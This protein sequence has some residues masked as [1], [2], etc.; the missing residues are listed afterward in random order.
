MFASKGALAKVWLAAFQAN[1]KKVDAKMAEKV[2][3]KKSA[4]ALWM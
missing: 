3:I 4:G 2:D 1:A